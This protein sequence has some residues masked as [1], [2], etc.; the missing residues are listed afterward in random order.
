[1]ITK[2]FIDLIQLILDADKFDGFEKSQKLAASITEC[3][4]S[5]HRI[6]YKE[7]L[8]EGSIY[9]KFRSNFEFDG[10]HSVVSIQIDTDC[11]AVSLKES[12]L[13]LKFSYGFKECPYED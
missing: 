12:V 3:L 9:L 8:E 2:F 6:S 5:Y 1:M 7:D 10:E 4:N 13:D 11:G